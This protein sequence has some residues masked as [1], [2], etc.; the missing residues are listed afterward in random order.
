MA[1]APGSGWYT[2]MDHKEL[3]SG[4]QASNPANGTVF[5]GELGQAFIFFP[6]RVIL[7]LY[8]FVYQ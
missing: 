8:C 4:W 7:R 3:C 6:G 1:R 2:K 5:I